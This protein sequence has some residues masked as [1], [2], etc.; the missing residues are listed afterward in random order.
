MYRIIPLIISCS[1]ICFS[2]RAQ[3]KN[4][5][6][7]LQIRKA[8]SPIKI[9]GVIDEAAWLQADIATGFHMVLPMDTS[10]ARL[11]TDVRMTYDDKNLY[12]VVENY[13]VGN[14]PYMVES[15][16]R[17]F[18]FLK[19]DNFLLFMDPFDDQT[20]GFSFGANAAGAQWDGL[21]YD[22]GKVDLSWDNKWTS[23]VKNYPDKWV[24]EAVIPFKT[25]R[26]KKGITKWGINFS[27]NDLKTTEKSAWAPVP[28]QFPTASLAYTGNLVW[29]AAPP[30]AGANV[31][32]IPYVLG[33][34]LKD[35]DKATP[36][37]YRRDAG[38]DAKVAV[39]S[40]LNLD[41]TVNPDFSQVDVDKQVTNLDRF[42]LF[43]PEK[44][45]FFLENG[46]QMS[47]FG[48]ATIR[49]FFS[50]RIGLGGVPIRFGA[51]LSGKLNKDWRL[52]IMNME[53]GKQEE[54]G[55]PAQNFTVAAL[56]RRVFSRSNIGFIFINKES[57]NY[58]PSKVTDKPLYNRYNRN[59]GLEYNLASSNNF[60]TGKAMLL[61]SY[62]PNKTGHD[63]AHAANL[64]YTSKEW[65]IG[66]QHE[67]VGRNYNAEVGYVPRQGYI[68]IAPQVTRLFFPL[69][70][71]VLSHGPQ[72]TSTWFFDEANMHR[73]DNE[74]MLNYGIVFRKR[75][76][77][78]VWASNT[79]IKL[80][81]PFDP[82]NTGK[83]SLVN[84]SRHNWNTIGADYVSKPQSLFTYSLSARYG[85][86]Y[87]DGSRLM[88][89]TE[90]GY[91]FQ[92]YVSIALSANYN[93]I[94]LP[95]PWGNN[96]FWLVG[97]RLDVTMTNTLFFT[98]FMQYNGQQK[99]MN[100]N[101]R[102]QW[103]YRPA[104]DLFIVYTDNYLPEPFYVRNRAL[105]LKLVYWL[106]L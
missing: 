49:P 28:R 65:N 67:Y 57:V 21:M 62:T 50:R 77:L 55:L 45:Q 58:D 43:Y 75:N 11:R 7:Q 82:T 69:S 25:I 19:N 93:N 36:T 14:G 68:K 8:V 94:N 85:G 48:Y 100:L 66:W 90:L 102:F 95:K 27:R 5:A 105:V 72:V 13:T 84:G 91:R 61:K 10:A 98:G 24:F 76:T 88:T 106:N 33:G 64:Q 89:N 52:G 53:T 87:A 6:Y 41:L 56:Q 92:P 26:Y 31:S 17:D 32:L 44:R 42:E 40:S 2:V 3:K 1:F 101:T 30:P 81:Q 47:N 16:R 99:N 22:G 4:D 12:L 59:M 35:Y 29:D 9:D 39:T 46:D 86:Y 96:S 104:S 79:Y 78:N 54:T 97:P 74:T 37:K 20:N 18:A 63:I 60:W 15:L 103:R 80:L 38:L 51:R 73:T 71:S 34:M 70:G 23:V 83:D